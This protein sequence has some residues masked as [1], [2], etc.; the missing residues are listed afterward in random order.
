MAHSDS[1]QRTVEAMRPIASIDSTRPPPDA[2]TS[3]IVAPE[4]RLALLDLARLALAAA[5]G[6][7]D[8]LAVRGA[9]QNTPDADAPGVV[10]VTLTE[11]GALRGCMGTFEPKRSLREAVV[12]SA[13]TAALDDPRF[14]PV[15][16]TELPAIHIEI[17]VLGPTVPLTD[18]DAFRPGVDGVIVERDGRRGL[19]LPEVATTFDWGGP[20]MLDAVCGK[21]GLPDDAWRDPGTRLW[22]FRTVRFGGPAV[23]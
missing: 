1:R 21:A 10:F 3:P 20:R 11:D 2:A 14:M 15:R 5:T 4:V 13:F 16:A 6:S 12:T 22:T 9:L 18:P 17:S 7:A 8:L 19:L 23:E